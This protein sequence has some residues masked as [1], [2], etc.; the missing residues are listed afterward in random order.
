MR[1]AII[2]I[3]FSFFCFCFFFNHACRA[4]GPTTIIGE[5][6]E[7]A[8]WTK[9]NS[10]YKVLGDV[11]VKK[12]LVIEAGT[13]VKFG[14]GSLSRLNFKDDFYVEGTR[15]DPV[16]FTSMRDDSA[17]GDT[18]GDGSGTKPILGDWGS[19]YFNPPSDHE[20]KINH[21]VIHYAGTGIF[22]FASSNQTKD[23]IVK[24]CDIQKNGNGIYVYNAE[25]KIESNAIANNEVGILVDSSTRI[26]KASN[27]SITGNKRGAWGRNSLNPSLGA[28]DARYNW[29]GD[30]DGPIYHENANQNDTGNLV[31][32]KVSYDPWIKEDPITTPDPVIIIPGIMG[33]WEKDGK[34]QIDPIFHTYDNLYEE[35]QK[36]GYTSK[37]NLFTFPYQWRD[38]NK[39]NA[40]ELKAKIQDIKNQTHRPKVDIIAHSMGGL[41]AR[42]YIESSYYQNDV[43]Q[44]ITVGTPQLGAPKDYIKW[45]AGESFF[46]VFDMFGKRIFSLEA[47]INGFS[48]VYDYIRHRPIA[49]VQELL[50]VYDYLYD[51]NGGDNII[52]SSYPVNY[53][54]NEFLEELS[55]QSKI[56]VLKNLEFT[57]IIGKQNNNES[58]ISGYNVLAK[59]DGDLWPEGYPRN[60]NFPLL[61]RS[62]INFSDGDKTV[63]IYSAEAADI[64]ASRTITLKSEHN[65]LPTDAQKDILEILTGERPTNEIRKWHTPDILMV[66]VHCPIDVQIISPSGEKMG[67]NFKNGGEY[68]ET[69]NA[70]YTGYDTKTEFI[71]IPNPEDGEYKILTEGTGT[72]DYE[73]E[74]VK[75]SEDT[76]TD[77][78]SV[79]LTGTAE[80]EKQE[81]AMIK[82]EGATVEKMTIPEPEPDNPVDNPENT[83]SGNADDSSSGDNAVIGPTETGESNAQTNIQKLDALKGRV[84]QYFKSNQIK[85]RKEAAKIIK[86]LNHIRIYL[87]RYEIETSSKKRKIAKIKANKDIKRLIKHINKNSPKIICAEAQSTLITDLNDLK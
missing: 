27:N 43:D 19:L 5:I 81:E 74:V 31:I 9:E 56:E 60:F 72:G 15:D 32:E 53:P 51:V 70:F 13:V 38:S 79:I 26:A 34:W 76:E 82:V 39:V 3:S 22:I 44:L 68:T 29:W 66:L 73:I 75:F 86:E 52:R 78:S 71:T 48:S 45:E 36:N 50:P 6:N 14:T 69:E 46:D 58:T 87:K 85:K 49:S 24:N 40:V 65:D 23:R 1:R 59:S 57:K 55:K 17:M 21:A 28:L 11:Q 84:R 12:S 41:L 8:I 30:K 4:A 10:P 16:V 18:N 33:S 47:L 62:G 83:N 20:M 25:P 37:E 67:K 77:G 61:W 42:E 2:F 54:R 7:P 64:P 35:F 80:P 63:P